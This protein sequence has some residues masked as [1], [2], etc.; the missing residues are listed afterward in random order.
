MLGQ[1]LANQPRA[2]GAQR[3]T[4]CHLARSRA[5]TD[6]SEIGEVCTRDQQDN[7]DGSEEKVQGRLYVQTDW[8]RVRL[9]QYAVTVIRLRIF[10]S[11]AICDRGHFRACLRKCDAIPQLGCRIPQRAR[12]SR[13]DYV[14]RQRSPQLGLDELQA[15]SRGHNTDN[16][17]DLT[18]E[19]Y[20]PSED[21]RVPP[22][23][24]DPQTMTDYDNAF[25]A[26][27]AVVRCEGAPERWPQSE[28]IKVRGRD[29]RP[30]NINRLCAFADS[31]A[32]PGHGGHPF[33]HHVLAGPVEIIQHGHG[34]WA[35]EIG[36]L[37]AQ[38]N[39]SIGV[40]IRKRL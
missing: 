14:K 2:P 39:E 4:D 12:P 13:G 30:F 33:E 25:V 35:A 32:S 23:L 5:T 31:D 11:Q 7:S 21:C 26:R 38:T 8:P 24:R 29:E 22:K 16:G 17:V 37:L 9:Y 28:H 36:P 15:R 10:T 19:A 1:E 6:Q 18:V 20:H 34:S 27:L 40:R 3:G